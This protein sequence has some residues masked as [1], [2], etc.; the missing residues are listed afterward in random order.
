MIKS[1]P[2]QAKKYFW[3]DN[4]D[5]LDLVTHQKYIAQTLLEKGD[6]ASVSWLLNILTPKKLGR[7]L[8]R[9]KLSDKSRN[10]WAIYLS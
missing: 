3:G 7:M 5:Q 1:M 8:P 4:L 6:L 2:S 10:F 9:L